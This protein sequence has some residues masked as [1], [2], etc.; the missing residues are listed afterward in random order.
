MPYLT[1]YC[2]CGAPIRFWLLPGR[3]SPSADLNGDPVRLYRAKEICSQ[4]RPVRFLGIR[5]PDIL[6]NHINWIY[7]SGDDFTNEHYSLEEWI[8][9]FRTARVRPGNVWLD[10]KPLDF[11]NPPPPATRREQNR[12]KR[13][14]ATPLVEPALRCAH[15]GQ[16]EEA[17]GSCTHCGAPWPVVGTNQ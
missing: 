12:W 17:N 15:C 7:G 8:L 11:D 10:G 9:A 3:Y 14:A 16:G 5:L 1:A 2:Q 4:Y 6:Q 13:A